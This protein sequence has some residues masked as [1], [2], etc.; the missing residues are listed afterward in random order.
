MYTIDLIHLLA[1]VFSIKKKIEL[2]K[3][4]EE[5]NIMLRAFC[6]NLGMH[7]D[8]GETGFHST[9][10]ACVPKETPAACSSQRCLS[11]ARSSYCFI[12]LALLFCLILVKS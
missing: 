2:M 8:P 3:K 7:L 12:T 5:W 11:S 1:A 4:S 10:R 9:G 6:H